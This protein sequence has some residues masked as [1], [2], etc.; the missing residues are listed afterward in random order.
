[1]GGP[2]VKADARRVY[3]VLKTGGTAIVPASVGY[4]IMTTNP[5]ALEKLF[6]T[7]RR[8]AHKRHGMGGSYELHR[9]IHVMDPI[10][11]DITYTLTQTFG[12][13]LGV[14]SRFNEQH[15]MIKN[16][17]ERT[18]E[19][20]TNGE[21]MAMLINAGTLVDEVIKLTSAENM[22]VLGSSANL[23]GTGSLSL[24]FISDP[25]LSEVVGTK[26]RVE[27]INKEIL[28]I[29]DIVIDYGLVKWWIHGGSSTMLDF[30]GKTIKVVRFGASYDVIRDHLK[31]FFQ[32][33]LPSDPGRASLPS[34]HLQVLQPL[35][36]LEKLTAGA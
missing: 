14:I 9:Q 4:A 7:K 12:L 19:A 3:K 13:T 28:D 18:M 29:A 5:V 17:D 22:P 15:P 31:R 25:E 8:G 30:S 11:A 20:A 1:M 35:A 10:S 32:I 33:E 21:T 23:S 24:A 6:T 2:D 36:S 27:D 26:Y 34:G 16:I